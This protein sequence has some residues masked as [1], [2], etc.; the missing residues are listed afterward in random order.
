MTI[1]K[2]KLSHLSRATGYPIQTLRQIV[3]GQIRIPELAKNRQYKEIKDEYMRNAK[4]GLLF[5]RSLICSSF[6]TKDLIKDETLNDPGVELRRLSMIG[7][8]FGNLF[9][10]DF[11]EAFI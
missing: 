8:R 2:V 9:K 1:K 10:K 4:L 3:L 5:E 11:I 7:Q 6:Y